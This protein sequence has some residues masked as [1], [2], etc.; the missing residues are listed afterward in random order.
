MEKTSLRGIRFDFMADSVK[1][2]IKGYKGKF[3]V[4]LSGGLDSSV[5][6]LLA[7]RAV[8]SENILGVIMPDRESTLPEDIKD[9]QK[10]VDLLGIE[11]ETLH[12][13]EVL[14]AYRT[15]L[16]PDARTLGNLKAR[17]RMSLLYIF[18]N[19][20]GRIVLG[21]GDKSEIYLGYFTKYGDGGVDILPIGDIYK[22]ELRELASYLGVPENII[23][24]KSS[25][26]LWQGQLA[27]SELGVTYEYA[28]RVLY[29]LIDLGEDGNAIIREEGE[30]ARRV[31][32]LC[33]M[34]EHKRKMPP[35]AFV[36]KPAGSIG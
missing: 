20:E 34:S 6:A 22:T 31:I 9:A 17:I 4:G 25:P 14:Q 1:Q 16:N 3:V 24:K 36:S 35:I 10:M 2:F 27:E 11:S 21:T 5:T 28:D 29:R 26:R 23:E 32:E 8:G 13:D 15:K 30:R 7:S 33:A 12:I 18:A 19:S